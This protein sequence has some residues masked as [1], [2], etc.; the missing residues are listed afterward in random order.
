MRTALVAIVSTILLLGQA[1]ACVLQSFQPSDC[2]DESG[3]KNC[4]CLVITNKCTK[5]I[6]VRF[7]LSGA[8]PGSVQIAPDQV[9]TSACTMRRAQTISYVGYDLAGVPVPPGK[10]EK[11]MTCALIHQEMIELRGAMRRA[12]KPFDHDFT[13]RAC[14][15]AH[16]KMEDARVYI[17]LA[18]NRRR[19]VDVGCTTDN[20][21]ALLTGRESFAAQKSAVEAK[22]LCEQRQ[23]GSAS[24]NNDPVPNHPNPSSGNS[25]EPIVD[26]HI[27]CFG[28]KC[29]PERCAMLL[30]SP[31]PTTTSSM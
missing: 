14:N 18:A 20:E 5:Q 10:H 4:R 15:D 26:G 17:K 27:R 13:R 28:G 23:Q 2:I 8:G 24:R 30:S 22:L 7:V 12:S 6:S 1:H 19:Y 29:G 11:E 9:D 31:T 21:Y 25:D 16:D 3:G